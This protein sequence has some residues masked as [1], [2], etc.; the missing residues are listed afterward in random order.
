MTGVS[1]LV[2]D[3]GNKTGVI[4]DLR[5]H[6]RI[7]EDV[8]DRLLVASRRKE[9]RES[10]EQVRKRLARRTAKSHVKVHG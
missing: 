9:P 3:A 5:K 8:Y 1:F 10:L 2:D 6:R 4:L 7:W